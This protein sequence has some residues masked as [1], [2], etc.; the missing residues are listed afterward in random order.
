MDNPEAD[1][2][3]EEEARRR[4][5]KHDCPEDCQWCEAEEYWKKIWPDKR[6]ENHKH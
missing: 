3:D 1:R 6:G 2:L 5:F 4:H